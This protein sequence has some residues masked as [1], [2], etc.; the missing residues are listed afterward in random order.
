MLIVMGAAYLSNV[1]GYLGITRA[2]TQYV[3]SMG[4]TPYM[5][6]VILTV[7][8]LILGCLVDGFSMIVMTAPIVLPLIEAAKFDPVWF[9]IYLVLMIELAQITPP[10]GFNLFVISGLNNDDLS[11]VARAAF[12]FFVIML[13]ATVLLTVFPEIAL[14]LPGRMIG[15]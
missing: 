8:Y 7:L 15:K 13:L 2:L 1:I 4:L 9:G 3:T 6:I 11:T 12:P 14:F 5:L 10:V